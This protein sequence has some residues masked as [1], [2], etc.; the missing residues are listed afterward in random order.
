MNCEVITELSANVLHVDSPRAEHAKAEDIVFRP[1]LAGYH[2]ADFC[3]IARKRGAS[4][5]V[6]PKL[7]AI[8]L[9]RHNDVPGLNSVKFCTFCG[10]ECYVH[11]N[12]S[13]ANPDQV[14]AR[15][16]NRTYT[17]WKGRALATSVQLPVGFAVSTACF[18][19]L[20]AV[21]SVER[22]ITDTLTGLERQVLYLEASGRRSDKNE[23][24][25]FNTTDTITKVT[26]RTRIAL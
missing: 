22:S 15:D 4:Y 18:A 11:I 26:I 8:T 3:E 19:S 25:D 16:R 24:V 13:R 17:C 5:V 7:R 2:M 23:V 6:Y 1:R 9:S 10:I 20:K 21:T 12:A 14:T